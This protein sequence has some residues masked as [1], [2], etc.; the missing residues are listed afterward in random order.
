MR[1]VRFHHELYSEGAVREAVTIFSPH[2]TLERRDEAA[3]WVV[4]ISSA[5][6]QRER[7]VAGELGNYALGLT[8]KGRPR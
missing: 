2:A 3:H 1:L 4:A 6:P 5:T 8:V 7:R